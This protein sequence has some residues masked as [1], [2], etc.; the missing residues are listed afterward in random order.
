MSRLPLATR[1]WSGLSAWLTPFLSSVAVFELFATLAWKTNQ[2]RVIDVTTMLVLVPAAA[3][4]IALSAAWLISRSTQFS[5]GNVLMWSVRFAPIAWAVPIFDLI[6]SYGNGI[7]T[8]PTSL[9]GL[10]LFTSI[11]TCGLFP[12]ASGLTIGTRLGMALASLGIAV[13]IWSLSRRLA[14]SI[15]SG[16][17]MS[18]ILT[19]VVHIT[20]LFVFIRA[21][22][23]T[24]GWMAVHVEVARRAL[25]LFSQGY[26]WGNPYERFP[27]A[28]DAEADIAN[29]MA[30]SAWLI[31]LLGVV[32][33]IIAIT[34]LPS[35]KRIARHVFLR[36]STLEL[37]IL[38]AIGLAF[39]RTS[40]G[41][42][43]V[44]GALLAWKV[45]ILCLFALHIS[46][47]LRNDLNG[48]E[49]A[50]RSKFANP[51][52]EGLLP[53]E[54]ARSIASGLEWFAIAAAWTLGW[55]VCIGVLIFIASH[56]LLRDR[57]WSTSFWMRIVLRSVGA[58]GIALAA[59][60]FGLRSASLG[61][62]SIASAGA[63]FLAI[64][65]LEGFW[66]PRLKAASK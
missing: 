14:A 49:E 66:L 27:G 42:L 1:P 54:R 40:G 63:A 53:I 19:C 57:T 25:L 36:W 8:G 3:I 46:T 6:R 24:T 65:L 45:L 56:R 32:L 55:P 60:W 39:A 9:N 43:D 61:T 37:F 58:S 34:A 29:R 52:A 41:V 64:A 35:I 20:S 21:P 48:L 12:L 13:V 4:I 31:V 38:S 16:L 59:Q 2:G 33:I 62:S 10:Q 17:A 30:S 11:I 50:E 7:V 5:F 51:I 22:F 44:M 26:W 18:V 23:S 28:L 15:M 47:V